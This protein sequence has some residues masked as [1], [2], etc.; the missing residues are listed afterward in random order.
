MSKSGSE[1]KSYASMRELAQQA[2]E[3][4]RDSTRRILELAT[5]MSLT[6]KG[7]TKEIR[8]NLKKRDLAMVKHG[9]AGGALTAHIRLVGCV[10]PLVALLEQIFEIDHHEDGSVIIP[11]GAG[12]ETLLAFA[13]REAMMGGTPSHDPFIEVDMADHDITDTELE[14]L[15]PFLDEIMKLVPVAR[16]HPRSCLQSYLYS[17]WFCTHMSIQLDI[18]VEGGAPF[19]ELARRPRDRAER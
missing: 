6:P 16:A 2:F 12:P 7:M 10:E 13:A 1:P 19:Y 18:E 3:Y 14:K 11:D 15:A 17:Q 4:R 9:A 8:A 5:G